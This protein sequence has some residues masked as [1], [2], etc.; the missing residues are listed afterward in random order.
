VAAG[1][2]CSGDG[3]N[4]LQLIE[5]TNHITAIAGALAEQVP[6]LFLL[7]GRLS[8][9][10]RGHPVPQRM[11]ERRPCTAIP[12]TMM[13]LIL[14]VPCCLLK[15]RSIRRSKRSMSPAPLGWTSA[16]SPR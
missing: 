9:R 1:L 14:G 13:K 15:P 11:W 8:A 6:N 12:R 16:P 3:R 2:A 7:H 10:Q 5:P 4:L